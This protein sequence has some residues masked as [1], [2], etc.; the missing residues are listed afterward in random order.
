MR[1]SR[2]RTLEAPILAQGT[3]RAR[4]GS[5]KRPGPR[6]YCQTVPFAFRSQWSTPLRKPLANAAIAAS[7]GRSYSPSAKSPLPHGASGTNSP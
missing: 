2:G 4:R 3:N 5:H 6:G 7:R 1:I